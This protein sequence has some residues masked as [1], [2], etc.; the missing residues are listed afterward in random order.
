MFFNKILFGKSSL[1]KELTVGLAPIVDDASEVLV[2]GSLPSVKSLAKQEYYGNPANR[3]WKVLATVVGGECPVNYPEKLAFLHANHI[4]LWDVIK[5][6]NRDGS[7]DSAITNETVND[8]QGL[9]TKYKS[10]H[11]IAFNGK[12]A[13]ETY[14][15]YIGAFNIRHNIR[16]VTLLSTSP[17]NMQYSME[18]M[19]AN[20]Q[21]AIPH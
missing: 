9:L 10:I 11:T 13:A 20:W 17:A 15:K 2:L 12:K 8:I 5:Q 1:H 3:F 7:M 4:A 6:A 19:I 14:S 18:Q 21:Q 16:F